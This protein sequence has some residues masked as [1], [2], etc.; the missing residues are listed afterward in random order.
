VPPNELD[1]MINS[2]S[3]M[4]LLMFYTSSALLPVFQQQDGL[5]TPGSENSE[6]REYFIAGEGKGWINLHAEWL[7]SHLQATYEFIVISRS[8]GD[9]LSVMLIERLGDIAI[10]VGVG[11]VSEEVWVQA[12]LEWK[13]I[14]LG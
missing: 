7:A 9:F 4:H 8:G 1:A 2:P 11:K 3:K 6:V 10:R 12:E 13:L 5:H 14:K